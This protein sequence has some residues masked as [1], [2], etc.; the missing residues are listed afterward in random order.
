MDIR[1]SDLQIL[2]GIVQG[3]GYYAT[4]SPN[5]VQRLQEKGLIKNKGAGRLRPTLKGR[6]VAR[7][8]RHELQQTA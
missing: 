8:R 1:L 4:P 5:R 2:I 3:R 7:L 6:F